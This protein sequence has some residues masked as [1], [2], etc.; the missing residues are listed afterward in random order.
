MLLNKT[1]G[2]GYKVTQ[3]IKV[4]EL[5]G[6]YSM[7]GIS[8]TIFGATGFIGN[9]IA[10]E[11]GRIGSDLICPSR[12]PIWYSDNVKMLRLATG[13][14]YTYIN[15]HTNFQDPHT[16]RRLVE[17]SNVVINCAGPRTKYRRPELFR[18]VNV[19][20]AARVAR[21]ARLAG[22]KRLIHF[23]SVGVDPNSPSLD[24]A[25]KWEGEQRV[26]EE[27]PGA[28]IL[29]LTTAIG[30]EDYFV[31]IFR[32]KAVFFDR[33]VPVFSDLTAK[34]QP[35][36]VQDVANIVLEAIKQTHSIGQTYEIG[37]PHVYTLKEFYDVMAHS[38][39]RPLTYA[40]IDPK[41]GLSFAKLINYDHL[42]AEAIRKEQLDL[43]VSTA[44]GTK[45][46]ADLCY[47]PASVIPQVEE[48]I[49]RWR[50]QP[51][52]TKDDEMK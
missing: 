12:E 40:K 5:P 16:I 31:R 14:G 8:A 39:V 9:A 25:T 47:Q 49:A 19:D 10:P 21:Q 13:V 34:R 18:E 23:S 35:I 36:L 15:H 41:I 50:G 6:L 1:L 45:T 48:D 7:S 2:K 51:F 26:R 30:F 44:T 22:V 33:F 3:A 28:T 4:F 46:V 17:K 42:S 24:L 38:F 27:F 52:V 20:L 43:I 11:L 32:Q 29:R 37:G